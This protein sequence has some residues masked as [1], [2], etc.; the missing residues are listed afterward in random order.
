MKEWY[1]NINKSKYTPPSFVFGIV[2]PLLYLTMIISFILI[3]NNNKCINLCYPI[4][5]FLI[6]TFFNLIWTTIF[7]KYKNYLLA[8]IDLILMDITLLYIIYLFYPIS[9]LASLLLFPYLIW[10]FFATYLTFY[11][12]SNNI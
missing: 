7:F 6:H 8:L 4:V 11:I 5:I 2:W 1:M 9:K 10:I 3:Y 12:F